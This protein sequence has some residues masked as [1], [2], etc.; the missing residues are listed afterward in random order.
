MNIET[1][2]FNALAAN[3]PKLIYKFNKAKRLYVKGH[4]EC[5]ICGNRKYLECHHVIPVHVDV[6]LG[7]DP[8]NFITL[9][10]AKNNGCH[11]WI[12]H[13]GNF[14]SKWYPN[15]REYA[16]MSRILLEISQPERDFIVPTS[17]MIEEFSH[18]LGV[19]TEKFLKDAKALINT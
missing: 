6:N 18:S 8:N 11:R 10:D 14:R 3:D 13:F 2:V 19:S 15:V 16:V 5:A 1:F 17:Q 9:C 7:A 12:G 4:K